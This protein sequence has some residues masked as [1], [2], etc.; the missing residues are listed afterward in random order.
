MEQASIKALRINNNVSAEEMADYLGISRQTYSKKENG[1]REF[2]GSELFKIF[3]KFNV[4][5]IRS[6]KI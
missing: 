2:T 5:D 6:V 3:D 1:L 4:T